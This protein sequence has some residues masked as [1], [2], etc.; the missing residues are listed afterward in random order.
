MASNFELPE[1]RRKCSH[2]GHPRRRLDS[3]AL[4][5]WPWGVMSIIAN[6]LCQIWQ[7]VHPDLVHE[8]RPEELL[9]ILTGDCP[10]R[11]K[12]EVVYTGSKFRFF[13]DGGGL[14]SPGHI[15]PSKRPAPLLLDSVEKWW[16][17]L[18]TTSTSH[19][20]REENQPPLPLDIILKLRRTTIQWLQMDPDLGLT[21]V[22][23][24]PFFLELFSAL[25]A[26]I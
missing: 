5:R 18:R 26:A 24:Q 22:P 11:R 7:P 14:P 19:F 12:Q 8:P 16:D 25:A 20:Q 13:R 17:D 4:A 21:Q 23:G 6:K 9:Q 3:K 2:G 10:E 1:L 15:R